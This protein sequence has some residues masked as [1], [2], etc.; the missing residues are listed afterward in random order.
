MRVSKLLFA[1]MLAAGATS[2]AFGPAM[3]EEKKKAAPGGSTAEI[4][5]QDCKV[6]PPGDKSKPRE[7]VA[8]GSAQPCGEVAAGE[9]KAKPVSKDK[10]RKEVAKDAKAAAKEGATKGGGGPN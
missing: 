3:A 4:N 8:A 1:L 5:A 7:K 10:T 9:G 2:V 6:A